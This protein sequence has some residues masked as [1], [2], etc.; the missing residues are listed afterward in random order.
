MFLGLRCRDGVSGAAFQQRFH[1]ALP[2]MFPHVRELCADGLLEVVGERWQL[3]P[4]GLR[5]ADGV[6]ATFL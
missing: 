5:L 2:G 3:T 6:F 1:L 4:A